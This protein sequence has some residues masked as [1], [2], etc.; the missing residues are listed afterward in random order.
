[1]SSLLQAGRPN[2]ERRRFAVAAVHAVALGL[3]GLR[4][5]SKG[6]EDIVRQVDAGGDAAAVG[7]AADG[8]RREVGGDVDA[9]QE[10]LAEDLGDDADDAE[11]ALELRG[12][13]R[14][15]GGERLQVDAQ[16]G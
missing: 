2:S 12:A 1:L 14:A 15:A 6:L 3:H 16:A 10:L 4:N 7:G 9:V 11:L 5:L 13:G 8:N